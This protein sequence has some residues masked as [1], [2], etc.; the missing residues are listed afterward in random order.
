MANLVLGVLWP[1]WHYPL[2]FV[3][4]D[5]F[6]QS[7]FELYLFETTA[8]SF[9][10]G[11]IYSSTGGSL[12]FAVLAHTAQNLTTST[13][14]NLVF[15]PFLGAL[16]SLQDEL[17]EAGVWTDVECGAGQQLRDCHR[18][19]GLAVLYRRATWRGRLLTLRAGASRYRATSRSPPVF[20]TDRRWWWS[21]LTTLFRQYR[22]ITI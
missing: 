17:I 15:N 3:G 14:E 20:A 4:S 10:L 16:S 22:N 19:A 21:N 8:I 12:L 1:C 7:P 11:W 5:I 2:F 9:V 18:V 13:V 6:A